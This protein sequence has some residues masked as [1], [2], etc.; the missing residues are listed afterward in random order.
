MT[1][2][3]NKLSKIFFF[4]FFL[5]LLT[6]S[7]QLFAEPFAGDKLEKFLF[8]NT[9][10][11]EPDGFKIKLN[12]YNDQ[13][14]KFEVFGYGE[15]RGNWNFVNSK[16]AVYLPLSITPA[17]QYILGAQ[18]PEGVI[19]FD[20]KIIIFKGTDKSKRSDKWE[21]SSFNRI[22]EQQRQDEIKRQEEIKKEQNRIKA[23][24]LK[25]EAEAKAAIAKKQT[26]ERA[27]IAKK[28]AEEQQARFE[29][30]QQEAATRKTILNG[31]KL[32]AIFS[33]ITGLSF[34]LY[35]FQKNKI[36]Q[37]NKKIV[38]KIKSSTLREKIGYLFPL[39]VSFLFL[40]DVSLHLLV[41]WLGFGY[42]RPFF[43]NIDNNPIYFISSGYCAYISYKHH[44]RITSIAILFS[45][46]VFYR[47]LG[48][49][50]LFN[51]F[52]QQ[53]AIY[54]FVF[55]YPTLLLQI[56]LYLIFFLDDKIDFKNLTNKI[57][58]KKTSA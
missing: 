27:A 34:Y 23:E 4:I 5:F 38:N 39:T 1:K 57:S 14:Y 18:V 54:L 3:Y 22:I 49:H 30:E 44:K 36:N 37:F 51:F 33:I 50:L 9:I 12:F 56:Y 16:K 52:K 28:E 13:T 32:I 24:Q 20:D 45:Y 19:E 35:K 17:K 31:I 6:P 2:F 46:I 8:E 29:K 42:Y 41:P 11:Y 26:E 55:A 47:M 40:I 48:D 21:Y 25:K 58:S 15:H 53:P 10:T 43:L 7:K